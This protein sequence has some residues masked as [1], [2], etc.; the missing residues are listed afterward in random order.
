[1]SVRE[2]LT[3]ALHNWHPSQHVNVYC[4]PTGLFHFSAQLCDME[5]AEEDDDLTFVEAVDWYGQ[6]CSPNLKDEPL[7]ANY[8]YWRRLTALCALTV[9]TGILMRAMILRVM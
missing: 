8:I 4:T 1:M 7:V 2:S 3:T 9:K 6:P 5:L